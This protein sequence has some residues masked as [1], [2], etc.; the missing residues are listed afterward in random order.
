MSTEK[1][2][3]IMQRY[4]E[5]AW[6]RGNLALLDKLIAP[7]YI[8]HNPAIPGLPPGPEGVKP[9]LAAFRQ[10]FPDIHF[11]IEDQIAEGELVVTRWTMQGTQHGELMGIPP[12]GK[13]VQ[14][15]G[16]ETERIVDDQIVEHWLTVD[17]L[18]MLQQLG[19]VP[20]SIGH[21]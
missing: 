1:N 5:E 4:F 6:N 8:N 13:Q 7:D 17:Q 9:I 20:V 2:K 3:V 11:T 16:V 19:I 18:G 12:M 14:V 15:A 21:E 10:A